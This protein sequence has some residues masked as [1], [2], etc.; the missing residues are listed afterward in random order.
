MVMPCF[1]KAIVRKPCLNFINGITTVNFGKPDYLKALEQHQL[2]IEALQYC[3]LEILILGPDENFPDSTF[4]EDTAILT[5]D[6][7]VITNPGAP[8]RNGETIEIRKIISQ[9]FSNIEEINYPG[10]LDGGDVMVVGNHFYIGLS[11][12]TNKEGTEQLID[13]LNRNNMT[14]STVE[15][16]N[17]LHLKSGI[18]YLENNNL[19]VS[20]EFKDKDEFEKY[21][22]IEIDDEESYA[23]NCV[24]INDY[25]LIAEGFPK[26]K[27]AIQRE[28]Y[29]TISLNMSE[30]Q[31]LD[32]GL[33]C[34]SLR[35]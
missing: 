9:F 11:Q 26:A 32:G 28:G 19:V 16:K 33:S 6:L 18:S 5:K 8:T 12:R 17:V 10:T 34:L 14:G 21:Y 7:A 4:V 3:G 13:I 20:G 23:A 25:V 29:K 30:F 22:R 1:S 27:K 15:L 24:W 35:Y 2:Y 31:K